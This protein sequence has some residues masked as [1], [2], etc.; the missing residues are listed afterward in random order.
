MRS[1]MRNAVIGFEE[2]TTSV[3]AI[4][5]DA[6]REGEKVV[7]YGF[8]S[9][10]R[11]AQSGLLRERFLRRILTAD[12]DTVLDHSGAN[13]D[14]AKI[15]RIAMTNEKPGG[16]GE[17]SV[18]VGI[19][20]M[21]LWDIVGKIEER[22]LCQVLA[23]RYGD[24]TCDADVAVYAAGGYYRER[25]V[26]ALQDEIRGYLELGYTTVKIKIGGATLAEDLGR[27]EAVI[28]LVGTADRVAVDANGRFDLPEA[29]EYAAALA[30]YRL[31]W[32]EEPGD[33]LDFSLHAVV[34]E[35]Y[36]PPIATGE[37]L[38]SSS[39]VRNLTRYGG[40]RPDR[41]VVQ[42]DPVLSYGVVEYAE[43]LR[44]LQ[45]HG[46]SPRRAIPHGGHQL[47]LHVASGLKLGGNESYPGV[48]EPFGGFAD[49]VPVIDGRVAV[50]DLPG[51]GFEANSALFATLSNSSHGSEPCRP[52]SRQRPRAMTDANVSAHRSGRRYSI[53]YLPGDGVG[54]EV[55]REARRAVDA[56]KVPVAWVELPWGSERWLAH[57]RMMPEDALE[58]VGELDAVLM[59]AI[60]DP[61]VPDHVSLW[62]LVLELRQR[63]DLWA[64]IR[65]VRLLPGVPG[66]LQL[67]GFR[68]VIDM[69][70]V[71]ENSE[72][73][74]AGVGGRSHRGR[75]TEVALE[76]SVFTRG[77]LERILRYAFELARQRRGLLTSA[78]KSNASRY[79]YV[80]WDEVATEVA[81][82][83]PDVE[84]QRVLVDALAARMI[85]NPGS[86][87]VV[88][89][90]N[91]FADILTD[92]GAEIQGGLGMASS[93]NTAPGETTPGVYEP[94][95]GA[96]PDIAGRGIANPCGAI[97][98]AA[99]MMKD[100]GEA[101][102]SNTVMQA[103]EQ[104]CLQGP[105]T[106]D[107]GGVARTNEVGDA[108]VTAIQRTV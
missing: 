71:R 23:D 80:L 55:L 33:P 43:M 79:G 68:G 37:N 82:D 21:A 52:L 16:H 45:T 25:G 28:E 17:R 59:G 40:L 38:F 98:S 31:R 93:S 63:L 57:K 89:A 87:D 22:P 47:A 74:Y 64:N 61:R 5:T 1:P 19:I 6:D 65:P 39:D 100:L 78:T 96:A 95:H 102:A 32:F 51:V 58:R 34:A 7:G 92:I 101:S 88:V 2:M 81:G 91:L 36:E 18:A 99:L 106:P 10:G 46:W 49:D 83:F 29:L 94:V 85:R 54:P 48:F 77:A 27:I 9:N 14:P 41:D 3:L 60:G 104:T 44:V 69:L 97:W 50:A 62:G 15:W 12:P 103:L 66:P 75:S 8:N 72:G 67:G 84:Y 76:T 108:V 42:M 73:E 86:L 4:E 20:D 70:F 24:G 107:I 11:Y 90:S 26:Q 53:G 30:P 35:A 105:H 56:T 13:L